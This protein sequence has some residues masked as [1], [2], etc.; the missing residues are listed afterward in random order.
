MTELKGVNQSMRSQRLTLREAVIEAIDFEMAVDPRIV[1]LG[2]DI[3]EFGGPLKS[4]EGLWERY[5]QS[6]IIDTPVAEQ[7]VVALGI[8]MSLNGLRPIIDLMF[9]DFLPLV[10]NE[11]LQLSAN[12][13]YM[14]NGKAVAPFVLRTRGGDGPYRAHPQN[15]EALLSNVPGL[16]VVTP[17][18]PASAKGLMVAS[19]RSDNPVVF[20]EPI[21]LYQG[22]KEDVPSEQYAIELGKAAV[23]RKGDDVTL[24][25]YGRTVRLMQLAAAKLEKQ[26][27]D[28][29]IVDLQTVTPFD[30][31]TLIKSTEKTRRLVVAHDAWMNCGIGAEIVATVAGEVDLLSRPV[32]LAGPDLP[33]A[34]A[35]V[36]RDNS[37]PTVPNVVEAV[38]RMFTNK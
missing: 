18:S 21:F 10:A 12:L 19:M 1:M 32:R 6:R 4:T 31:D 36:L 7:G 35:T 27:I 3:G 17:G 26:G 30:R 29:E 23:V 8:G 14:S 20:I 24:V 38:T 28:C 13:D 16:C 9:A 25:C 15:M 22:P 37:R 2:Q 5:G 34:Y 11:L 33:T